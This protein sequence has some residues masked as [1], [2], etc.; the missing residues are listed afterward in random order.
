MN[1]AADD[2]AFINRRASEVLREEKKRDDNWRSAI[3]DDLDLIGSA[4]GVTRQLAESDYVYRTRIA[5]KVNA[6]KP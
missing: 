2:Y 1:F 4:L 3:G 5:N 6:G